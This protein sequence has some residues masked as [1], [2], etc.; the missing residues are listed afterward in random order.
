MKP[1]TGL[2]QGKISTLSGQS[3]HSRPSELPQQTTT[4]SS[5][6]L[7]GQKRLRAANV[8]AV[9]VSPGIRYGGLAVLA[10]V[11][12]VREEV[13]DEAV[14]VGALVEGGQEVRIAV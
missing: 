1:V 12:A 14:L 11:D 4:S 2:S 5:T 7:L 8:S 9:E 6:C 13:T 3:P 10:L